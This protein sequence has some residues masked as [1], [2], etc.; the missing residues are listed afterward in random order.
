MNKPYYLNKLSKTLHITGC[1]KNSKGN[2]SNILLFS[3]EDEVLAHAGLTFRWCEE[4]R[5]WR[6]QMIRD[7]LTKQEEQA[8]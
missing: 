1:C 3:T 5:S 2:T 4:C 8:K 6:E 7:V